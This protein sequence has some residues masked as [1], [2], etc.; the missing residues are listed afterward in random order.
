VRKIK[1][2]RRTGGGKDKERERGEG[3]ETKERMCIKPKRSWGITNKTGWGI[4]IMGNG[5]GGKVE[6][7]ERG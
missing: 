5:G 1:I 2:A 6:Q 7:R 3:V 4:K